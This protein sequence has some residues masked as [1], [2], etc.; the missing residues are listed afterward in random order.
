VNILV[1]L[2]IQ[3]SKTADG[4]IVFKS[5]H[6]VVTDSSGASQEQDY[7]GSET[8]NPWER[9]FS[10]ADGKGTI[11]AQSLDTNGQPIGDPVEQDFDT[12]GS[13]GGGGTGEGNDFPQVTGITV[14]PV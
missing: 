12:A 5:N 13:G 2:T 14:T 3:T 6:V 8:P 11:V 9:Q 7:D 4:T 10:V 1:A